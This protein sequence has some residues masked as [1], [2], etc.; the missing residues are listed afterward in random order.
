MQR[1]QKQKKIYVGASV[2]ISG[3]SFTLRVKTTDF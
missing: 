1:E 3:L 2:E